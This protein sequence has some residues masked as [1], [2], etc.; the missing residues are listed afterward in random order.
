[1]CSYPYLPVECHWYV[2]PC[3]YSLIHPP[4]HTHTHIVP[5]LFI[6]QARAC[7]RICSPSFDP[8]LK[9]GN[10]PSSS[11]AN[12]RWAGMCVPCTVYSVRGSAH[13][14]ALSYT[15]CSEY[16]LVIPCMCVCK[17][18]YLCITYFYLLM[19][20]YIT[21]GVHECEYG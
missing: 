13:A 1:M 18:V 3:I 11:T 9:H 14:N 19:F 17:S 2:R 12:S 20:M 21:A 8:A 15:I 6:T 16:T 5:C 7:V 10:T 4:P